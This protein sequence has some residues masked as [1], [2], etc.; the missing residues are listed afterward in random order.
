MS[1]FATTISDLGVASKQIVEKHSKTEYP[2]RWGGGDGSG[3]SRMAAF[4]PC[5][6]V[7]GPTGGQEL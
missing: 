2:D 4:P 7:I 6:R 3:E 5:M 1:D